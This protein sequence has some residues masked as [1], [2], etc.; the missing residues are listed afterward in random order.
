[1][2]GRHLLPV[3]AVVSALVVVV[4]VGSSACT[5]GTTPDCTLPD[6]G[7]NPD[8]DGSLPVFDASDGG[9]GAAS[10]SPDEAQRDTGADAADAGTDAPVDAPS[11]GG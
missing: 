1:M 10:D 9:E 3:L 5:D 11:D 6:A 8:T 7:C 4:S 2:H